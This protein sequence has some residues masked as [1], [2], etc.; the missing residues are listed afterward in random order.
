MKKEL[1]ALIIGGGP[2]GLLVGLT[3][4]RFA[5]E[6]KR[7]ILIF[8]KEKYPHFKPCGGAITPEGVKILKKFRLSYD[9]GILFKSV[10]IVAAER[11]QIYTGDKDGLLVDRSDFDRWLALKTRENGIEIMENCPVKDLKYDGR[12]WEIATG[13][14][15]FAAEIIIGADGIRG[16]TRKILPLK[17]KIVPLKMGV[18]EDKEKPDIPVF[19]FSINGK[20]RCGYR[21]EFPSPGGVNS[22][23]YLFSGK[24][25]KEEDFPYGYAEHLY[26]PWNPLW[27]QGIILAGERVGVDPL[28][29]EGIAPAMEMGILAARAVIF[30]LKKGINIF[31]H[32][33]QSFYSSKTGKKLRFNL[34]LA[35][36]LYGKHPEYWNTLITENDLFPKTV[37]RYNY[38]GELYK[39]QLDIIKILLYQFVKKGLPRN[40]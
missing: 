1:K 12:R 23:I 22:G 24:F 4:S 30:A 7:E 31:P 10:K 2:A 39:H 27:A 21:W 36:R 15:N 38:Y 35:Q 40:L 6:L 20:H 34:V 26:S 16:I 9:K 17:G 25:K 8:E 14:G 32:Y 3:F 29:G 37:S 19:D 13:C 28:L 11:S 18:L 5:P 33:Y